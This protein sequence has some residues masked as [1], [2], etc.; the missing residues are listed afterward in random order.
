MKWFYN[1]KIAT[2]LILSYIII[3]ILSGVVGLIG[4]INI[5]KMNN[6]DAILYNNMT[7]PLTEVAEMNS[8]FQRARVN[9]RDMIYES[10]PGSIQETYEYTLSFLDEMSRIGDSFNKTII[11]DVVR[12]A[13]DEFLK[14]VDDYKADLDEYLELCLQNKDDEAYAFAKGDMQETSDELRSAIENLVNLKINHAKNQADSNTATADLSQL[15]MLTVIVLAMLVAIIMGI[16]VSRSISKPVRKLAAGADKIADGDL[17]VYIDIH[18][19]DEVGK[20]ADA[21]NRMANNLNDVISNIN[22]ASEQVAVGSKQVADSSMELSQGATEQASTIEELSASLE[23]IA[24]Q[25]KLNADNSNQANTLAERAKDNAVQGNNH[26]KDM[27]KA[28]EEIN[29]SSN[30]ISKIIKVIDDIAFQ[31]NILALNAAVEAARAGQ[32]GKGFAVVAEEVRNLAARSASAAKE[33]TEMIEDSIK[34]VETGTAIAKQTSDALNKI[35]EEV[36]KVAKLIDDIAVASNEQSSSIDQINQGIMMVTEVIQKT[37][38]TSEESAAAS[39][40]LSSQADL[41]KEQVLRFKLRKAGN[42]ANYYGG[43]AN[44]SSGTAKRTDKT[45]KKAEKKE[46][47]NTVN[48]DSADAPKTQQKKIILGDNEFGKY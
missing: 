30:N 46:V 45:E 42:N 43:M 1:M 9:S 12:E 7:V 39:E 26:M 34:N 24:N 48:K 44:F 21:F 6:D 27:L 29:Q 14:A 5:E 2:K 40:E 25:T 3:A 4:I 36:S 17:D 38:A 20:L 15:T 23:E 41:L 31:T 33:T 19:K 10:D 16:F 22:E 28:M 18:T 13:F 35:V 32:Y 8:L 47:I 11:Q 37:S